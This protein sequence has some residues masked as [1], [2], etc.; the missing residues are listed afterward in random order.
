M[1]S[2]LFASD[3]DN[4]LLFSYRHRQ[5]TD[6]CVELLEGKEQSFCTVRSLELLAQV[7]RKTRFV[8]VTTRS[9]SQYRRIHWPPDC[10]PQYA[11]TT[12]GGILLDNG[13]EDLDWHSQTLELTAPWREELSNLARRLPEAPMLRRSRIVDGLYLF[14]ACDDGESAQAG[15]A[16]FAGQTSLEIAV[17]GRKVY[18]FPPPLNKGTAVRRL[19]EKFRPD[20]VICAGDSVID[21]PMF[22]MA[23]L[24]LLPDGAL[25]SAAAG[26]LRVHR[27]AGRFPDFVLE[28]VLDTAGEFERL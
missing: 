2:I 22:P 18:F 6:Q 14:A 3:L 24:G 21:L 28:T 25:L 16:F 23:G 11:V 17:S 27:G 26:I 10:V 1:G 7:N 15:G 19:R 20:E 8:P 13:A 9:V 12:N 4:T 5:E